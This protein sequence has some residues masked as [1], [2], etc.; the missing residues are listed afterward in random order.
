MNYGI[1]KRLTRNTTQIKVR[2][3]DGK[4]EPVCACIDDGEWGHNEILKLI[5]I[6]K[7][8]IWCKHDK[9]NAIKWFH[10]SKD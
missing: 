3:D 2:H 9:E 8:L 7:Q 10:I 4:Y 1:S 5:N 6:K